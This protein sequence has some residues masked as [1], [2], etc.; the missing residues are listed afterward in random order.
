[1][2]YGDL[3]LNREVEYADLFIQ[4]GTRLNEIE[5][6][7]EIESIIVQCPGNCEKKKETKTKTK[8]YNLYSN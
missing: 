1:M 5:G 8:N 3:N 4:C 2:K 7:S 6:Y